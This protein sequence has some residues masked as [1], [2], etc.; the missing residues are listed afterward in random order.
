MSVINI[1]KLQLNIEDV[2]LA[3]DATRRHNDQDIN[4]MMLLV[5]LLPRVCR[6]TR[7]KLNYCTST[8]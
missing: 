5:S 4:N 7:D 1:H 8:T 3:Y 6:F 2:R